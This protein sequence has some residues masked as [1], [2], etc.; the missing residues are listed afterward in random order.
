MII[1]GT[2]GVTTTP[3]EGQFHCPQC[4]QQSA[5]KLKRV[6]R[7][8]TLYFIPVIP[9]DK[10][11]E[12]VECPACQVTYDPEILNYD[13]A[14][15]Q[16]HVEA[17]FHVACKQVMIAMLL[18]DGVVDDSEVTQLRDQFLSLTGTDVPEQEL[19]EEIAQIQAQGSSA[20][21]LVARMAPQLNDN[22]KEMVIRAAYAIAAADGNVDE[23]ESR[24]L[25]EVAQSLGMSEAHM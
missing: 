8:F 7:F 2:R 16:L 9:L 24:Y 17:L 6:R 18:A 14:Q 1:F 11:G 21:E 25:L 15:E 10:L 23:T 4:N 19:R 20:A 3:E 22:G 13:P 5:F 12:Y